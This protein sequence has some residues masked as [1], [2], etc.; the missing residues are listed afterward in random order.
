MQISAQNIDYLAIFW[1]NLE[2]IAAI[3]DGEHDPFEKKSQKTVI[4]KE[5]TQ[6]PTIFLEK[7]EKMLNKELE[8]HV[9]AVPR[10][11]FNVEIQRKLPKIKSLALDFACDLFN[12]FILS[13]LPRDFLEHKVTFFKIFLMNT[14]DAQIIKRLCEILEQIKQNYP[15]LIK[16]VQIYEAQIADST[17]F[18]LNFIEFPWNF[19]NSQEKSAGNPKVFAVRGCKKRV[20]KPLRHGISAASVTKSSQGIQFAQERLTFSNENPVV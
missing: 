10:G 12:S 20:S 7:F 6:K 15:A 2:Y 17:I 18:P 4:L 3:Y 1:E 19:S 13:G 8:T 16:N 5:D 9:S 14:S 11:D